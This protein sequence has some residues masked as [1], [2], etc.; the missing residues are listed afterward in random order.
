M[1]FFNILKIIKFKNLSCIAL[2]KFSYE[3]KTAM[4]NFT[5]TF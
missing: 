2:M 1:P 4:K 5:T 3:K